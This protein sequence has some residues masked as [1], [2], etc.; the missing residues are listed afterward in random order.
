MSNNSLYFRKNKA[1]YGNKGPGA[2]DIL[3]KR[4]WNP[5]RDK[6]PE[7]LENGGGFGRLLE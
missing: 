5:G 3:M 7:S 1:Y 4:L 2:E 6:S